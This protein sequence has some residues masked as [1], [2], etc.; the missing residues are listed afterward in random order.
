MLSS[1]NILPNSIPTHE[2]GMAKVLSSNIRLL[3]LEKL[4]L[5]S[6]T[7]SPGEGSSSLSSG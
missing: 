4:H 5:D 7:E 2:E 1:V 6:G 3:E